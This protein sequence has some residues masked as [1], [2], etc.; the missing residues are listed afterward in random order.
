M[1]ASIQKTY[2]AKAHSLLSPELLRHVAL[3]L[4]E[5]LNS[6]TSG[7]LGGPDSAIE[8]GLLSL[9]VRLRAVE[10]DSATKLLE[11]C[12]VSAQE[13]TLSRSMLQQKLQMITHTTN[14]EVA[15]RRVHKQ[16]SACTSC[17][18]QTY[19]SHTQH[20]GVEQATTS[21]T[22]LCL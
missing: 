16:D 13:T 4:A 11:F 6:V 10:A 2:C 12:G 9:S 17:D 3:R 5:V 14:G 7:C 19:A 20:R 1:H 21:T 8:K 18:D 22:S 15:E